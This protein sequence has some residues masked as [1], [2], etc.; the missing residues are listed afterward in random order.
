MGN[1]YVSVRVGECTKCGAKDRLTKFKVDGK[2]E[3]LCGK[4]L[5]PDYTPTI[6]EHLSGKNRSMLA[7]FEEK[8]PLD[9]GDIELIKRQI[10]KFGKGPVTRGF[11]RRVY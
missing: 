2:S 7:D 10:R 3:R 6:D 5:C 4:C 11:G 8:K 1:K 9:D